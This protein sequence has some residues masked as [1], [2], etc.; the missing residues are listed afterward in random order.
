MRALGVLVLFLVGLGLGFVS[1]PANAAPCPFHAHQP[2]AA[3]QGSPGAADTRTLTAAT[4]VVAAAAPD[5][6]ATP[7]SPLSPDHPVPEGQS[8]CHIAAA[9]TLSV[10]PVLEPWGAARLAVPRSWL[11]PRPAPATD[12]FRP[13]AFA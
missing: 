6:L 4:E 8:C 7:A 3:T 1:S 11:P 12:I 5:H 9:A 10:V 13:P 2:T